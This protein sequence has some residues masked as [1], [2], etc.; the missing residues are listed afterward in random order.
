MRVKMLAK[1]NQRREEIREKARK[2]RDDRRKAV[3]RKERREREEREWRGDE[4]DAN[5]TIA[6]TT[7]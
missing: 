6:T 4:E 1:K 5:N 2:L 3:Q 7:L